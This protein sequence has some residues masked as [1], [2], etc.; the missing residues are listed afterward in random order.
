MIISK[1]V[2]LRGL[3]ANMKKRIEWVDALK[4]FGIILVGLGH[5]DC[6]DSLMAW[7]YSFH[8]PLFFMLSGI[9]EKAKDY[10]WSEWLKKK[11]KSLLWPYIFFGIIEVIFYIISEAAV[12]ELVGIKLLKKIAAIVYSN[13][14]FDHNY[15][16]VIWFLSC[17]FVT[18]LLFF[19]I[20]KYINNR[21][22]RIAVT[23]VLGTLGLMWES[24]I[25]FKPPFFADIALTALL[26][27]SFGFL[28]R[29]LLERE[30]SALEIL[31]GFFAITFGSFLAMYNQKD[32]YGKHVSMLYLRYGEP[33]IFVVSACLILLGFVIIFQGIS[34][35]ISK[36]FGRPLIYLGRNS[37]IIFS[38]HLMIMHVLKYPIG[39]G[40]GAWPWLFLSTLMVSVIV[41]AL[42]NKF[43]RKVIYI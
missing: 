42:L 24:F 15:T 34:G 40:D 32:L 21:F 23:I 38:V 20:H 10:S 11:A 5:T 3:I 19:V 4:G 27:Y 13:Y 29:P 31:P 28:L 2:L 36:N 18:E 8:M 35:L 39:D 7:I 22:G 43:C 1:T 33:I 9:M 17:L 41:T 16:G 12:H 6:P 26:F 25:D 14:I 30:S 37:L